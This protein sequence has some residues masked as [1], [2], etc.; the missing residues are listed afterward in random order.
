MPSS[1]SSMRHSNVTGT[2]WQQ[3]GDVAEGIVRRLKKGQARGMDT[4]T[5][6][7]VAP[8]AM[9]YDS[10]ETEEASREDTRA[11]E[12]PGDR[13]GHTQTCLSSCRDS[14]HRVPSHAAALYSSMRT[15][16]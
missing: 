2:A 14:I 1:M 10:R 8:P 12:I 9:R 6:A 16:R 15:R 7:K 11:S 5:P 4:A 13:Y 3:V